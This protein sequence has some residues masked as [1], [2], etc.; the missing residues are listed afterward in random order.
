MSARLTM[1]VLAPLAAAALAGAVFG[2][3]AVVPDDRDQNGLF[4]PPGR[5]SHVAVLVARVV[6]W[7][8]RLVRS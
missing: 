6:G 3:V 7:L 5:S 1:T 8:I 2:G 4:R